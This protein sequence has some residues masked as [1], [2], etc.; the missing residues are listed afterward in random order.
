VITDWFEHLQVSPKLLRQHVCE[1]LFPSLR[2]GKSMIS[3]RTARRWLQRLGYRQKKHTKGVYWDGHERK[4]VRRRRAAYLKEME[5]I[6][7]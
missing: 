6:D 7:Q 3:L 4:D 5:D 1:T 2:V